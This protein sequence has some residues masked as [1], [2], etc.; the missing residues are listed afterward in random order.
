MKTVV[1]I[2]SCGD[3]EAIFSFVSAVVSTFIVQVDD[4]KGYVQ[5]MVLNKDDAQITCRPDLVVIDDESKK[6]E[7]PDSQVLIFDPA[8]KNGDLFLIK[9]I[10]ETLKIF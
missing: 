5:S 2:P 1:F 7:F 4:D 6:D 8:E 9:R 10:S 3:S